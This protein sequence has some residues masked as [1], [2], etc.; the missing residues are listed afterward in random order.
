MNL[1]TVENISKAGVVTLLAIVLITGATGV[2]VWGSTYN[3][4]KA[5]RDKWEKIALDGL[6]TARQ[7]SKARLPYMMAAPSTS[8]KELRPEDIK[9]QLE[10]I[11]KLNHVD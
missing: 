11:K 3:E 5:D 8:S 9:S 4:V 1:F 10:L 7:V 6:T 2:W